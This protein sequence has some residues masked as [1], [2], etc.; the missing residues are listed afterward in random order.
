MKK[1]L[2]ALALAATPAH[3]AVYGPPAPTTV[4]P[5]DRSHF[6]VEPD[7]TM[8]EAEA[9]LHRETRSAWRSFWIGQGAVAADLALTCYALAQRNPDG[10]RRFREGNPIYGNTSCGKIVAIR[11]AFSVAQYFLAKHDIERNPRASKKMLNIAIG[12]HM[13][14]VIWNIIQVTK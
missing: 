4:T 2:F 7:E 9:R 1:L 5:L 12:V 14:P 10:T 6:E 3:A 11:S 8:A 13:G